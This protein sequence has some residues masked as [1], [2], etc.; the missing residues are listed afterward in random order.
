MSY[1]YIANKKLYAAV[2]FACKMIRENGYFNKAVKIAANYYDVDENEVIAQVRARQSAGQKKANA[3]TKRKYKWFTCCIV[4]QSFGVGQ[5]DV[6][7]PF[8][9]RGLDAKNISRDE[10]HFYYGGNYEWESFET[11]MKEYETKKEAEAHL[12]KDFEEYKKTHA[13]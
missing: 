12:Q 2:M 5:Q 13:W 8:V 9:R 1:P 3:K 10:G 4:T 7:E 11:A 6:S